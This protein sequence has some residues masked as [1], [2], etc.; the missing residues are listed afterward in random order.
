MNNDVMHLKNGDFAV[1]PEAPYSSEPIEEGVYMPHENI[2]EHIMDFVRGNIES[3]RGHQHMREVL[4]DII[5]DL[6]NF[7]N[8]LATPEQ[9][10]KKELL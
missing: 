1:L 9:Y 8:A 4:D 6:S 2:E 3:S 10:M 5:V 7:R